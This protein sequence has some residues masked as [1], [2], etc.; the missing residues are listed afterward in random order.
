V[1]R[2]AF[3]VSPHRSVDDHLPQIELTQHLYAGYVELDLTW[4]SSPEG[5][6]DHG[7]TCLSD[8]TYRLSNGCSFPKVLTCSQPTCYSFST[9]TNAK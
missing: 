8:F 5:Q 6:P 2:R 9:I 1:Q 4:G 7:Q 3:A